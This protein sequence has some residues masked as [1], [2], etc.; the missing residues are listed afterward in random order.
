MVLSRPVLAA[1]V[2]AALALPAAAGASTCA[3]LPVSASRTSTDPVAYQ[4][5][6]R[7]TLS[8]TRALRDVRVRVVQGR[9]VLAAGSA[10]RLA[11]GRGLVPIRFTR[12]LGGRV[13][14]KV[15]GRAAG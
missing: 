3:K 9:H 6:G 11:K 14:V 4:D 8:A 15:S 12:I 10:K 1:A 7:L 5:A 2:A 13:T